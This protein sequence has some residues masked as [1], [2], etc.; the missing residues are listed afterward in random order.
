MCVEKKECGTFFRRDFSGRVFGIGGAAAAA[1]LSC[2]VLLTICACGRPATG[3]AK[4]RTT[5]LH[6]HT[7][8]Y[9][10]ITRQPIPAAL[11]MQVWDVTGRGTNSAKVR[12]GT[13]LFSIWPSTVP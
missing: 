9:H 7:I 4:H 12:A 11:Q 3:R 13:S 10:H 2:L 8:H 1:G 5:T 6:Y